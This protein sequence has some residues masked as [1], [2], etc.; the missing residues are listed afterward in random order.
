MLQGGGFGREGAVRDIYDTADIA[1]KVNLIDTEA[2]PAIEN[3]IKG[4]IQ[5]YYEHAERKSYIVPDSL[6]TNNADR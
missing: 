5:Q 6:S 1:T 4:Y 3:M 2:D